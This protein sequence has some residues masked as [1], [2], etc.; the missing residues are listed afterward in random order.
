MS[1]KIALTHLIRNSAVTLIG[2]KTVGP[3]GLVFL[4]TS[5]AAQLSQYEIFN[6]LEARLPNAERW[7]A[8]HDPKIQPPPWLV[9]ET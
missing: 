2:R 3:F 8:E 5:P 1:S 4:G 9:S 6:V 7:S